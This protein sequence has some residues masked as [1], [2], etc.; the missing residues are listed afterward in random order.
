M[1]GILVA[2]VAVLTFSVSAQTGGNNLEAINEYCASVDADIKLEVMELKGKEFLDQ[3]TARKS[4]L[5][6]YFDGNTLKKIE[7]TLGKKFS[8]RTLTYYYNAGLLVKAVYD[9]KPFGNGDGHKQ[10]ASPPY[11][12]EFWLVQE[13]VFN[14]KEEGTWLFDNP[15]NDRTAIIKVNSNFYKKKATGK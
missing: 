5:K 4:S 9:F 2:I 14:H 15:I 8:D 10:K 11:K 1:K 13:Y 12:G 6:A 7:V 3:P